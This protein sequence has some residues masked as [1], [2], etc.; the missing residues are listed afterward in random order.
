MSGPFWWIFTTNTHSTLLFLAVHLQT[1][2]VS[3][4]VSWQR[5]VKFLK[6]KPLKYF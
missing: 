6:A 1:N 2:N 5:N 3:L 4:I